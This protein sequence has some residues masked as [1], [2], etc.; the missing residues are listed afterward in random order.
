[1]S[2]VALKRRRRNIG[3]LEE[4]YVDDLIDL[5]YSKKRCP[6]ESDNIGE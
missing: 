6:R 2:A 1:M 3:D 5:V 4:Y